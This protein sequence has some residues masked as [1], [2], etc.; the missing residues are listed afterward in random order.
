V[1][2][3]VTGLVC[4]RRQRDAKRHRRLDASIGASGPYAVTS[5]TIAIRRSGG[6]GCAIMEVIW[7]IGQLQHIGTT[8]KRPSLVDEEQAVRDPAATACHI[9]DHRNPA[10]SAAGRE[11]RGVESLLG[12]A[13]RR[14][15]RRPRPLSND[16]SPPI[17]SHAR[18]TRAGS[19]E[20]AC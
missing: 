3:S 6:M 12:R 4:H 8:S 18:P 2:L 10:L 17:P 7:A 14:L 15:H 11:P 16:R 5:A 20:C 9:N 1:L 19:T 13:P